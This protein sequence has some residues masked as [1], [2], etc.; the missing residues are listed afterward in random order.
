MSDRI[1]IRIFQ[2]KRILSQHAGDTDDQ[3]VG[4]AARGCHCGAEGE[5]GG[6]SCWGETSGVERFT[7]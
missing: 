5:K 6:E 1:K 2:I 4:G 7:R 3:L